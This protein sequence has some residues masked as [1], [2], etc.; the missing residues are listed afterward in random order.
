MNYLRSG[1]GKT[2]CKHFLSG[3]MDFETVGPL[4]WALAYGECLGGLPTMY[5]PSWQPSSL[6]VSFYWPTSVPGFF[7]GE[8]LC[9]LLP[10]WEERKAVSSGNWCPWFR[11]CLREWAS[12]VLNCA[13][14]QLSAL[15]FNYQNKPVLGRYPMVPARIMILALSPCIPGSQAN[16]PQIF[17]SVWPWA[18]ESLHLLTPAK[19]TIITKTFAYFPALSMLSPGLEAGLWLASSHGLLSSCVPGTQRWNKA[20]VAT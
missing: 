1:W 8:P 2:N 18:F 19:V 17:A 15:G 13:V 12:L 16:R 6:F 14:S 4:V 10:R 5:W 20:E 11:A 7:L 3:E 9:L